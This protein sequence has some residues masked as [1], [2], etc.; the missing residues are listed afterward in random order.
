MVDVYNP[1]QVREEVGKLIKDIQEME[2]ATNKLLESLMN[3]VSQTGD[4]DSVSD[5]GYLMTLAQ[6]QAVN[7]T[8]LCRVAKLLTLLVI[9][10]SHDIENKKLGEKSGAQKSAPEKSGPA[11]SIPEKAV[12]EKQL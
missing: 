11:K 7:N 5:R 9:W 6:M 2:N 12:V 1:R 8:V 4:M 3:A 10:D